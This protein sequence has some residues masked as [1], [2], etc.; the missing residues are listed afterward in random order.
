MARNNWA[1]LEGYILHQKPY[2][3]SS[4]IAEFFS[5]D[6]GRIPLL[7][8]GL[9]GKNSRRK[10]GGLIQPFDHLA[11]NVAPRGDMRRAE[12][13][14]QLS[15]SLKVVGTR[16]FFGMYV[17]ELVYRLSVREERTPEIFDLYHR[18]MEA[19]KLESFQ[20]RFL[21]GFEVQ[22]LKALGY[23]IDLTRADGGEQFV[24]ASKRY[25][26]DP[27]VG[28][29]TDPLGAFSGVELKAVLSESDLDSS[30]TA[31]RSVIDSLISHLLRGRRINAR[32]LC[33]KY[34]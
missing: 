18:F 16:T 4:V 22:F 32:V 13:K 27:E 19:L 26:F 29:V 34:R 12:L 24:E 33:D 28:L 30:Q 15:S 1:L 8:N 7:F 25:R 14:D 17:N 11:I 5:R 6:E 31:L 20:V 2:R 21:T 23:A 10:A 3:E 9:R